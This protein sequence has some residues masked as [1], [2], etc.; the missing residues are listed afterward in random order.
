[1]NNRRLAQ[2]YLDPHLRRPEFD[3]SAVRKPL[4]LATLLRA[5]RIGELS[6]GR[7]ADKVERLYQTITDDEAETRAWT[8]NK[9]NDGMLVNI[10][11]GGVGTWLD[12]KTKTLDISEELCDFEING[13]VYRLGI[14]S[15]S[16]RDV[17]AYQVL[18]TGEM[19]P[20]MY[21]D[22]LLPQAED[23]HSL[24]VS[25]MKPPT[26]SVYPDIDLTFVRAIRACK[27]TPLITGAIGR[28]V[29]I[30]QEQGRF[31]AVGLEMQ[32]YDRWDSLD[33]TRY[34][35]SVIHARA[36]SYL[37]K[38]WLIVETIYSSAC[39]G[40]QLHAATS[41]GE[42][43]YGPLPM[44]RLWETT[45]AGDEALGRILRKMRR[46][47]I[48]NLVFADKKDVVAAARECFREMATELGI[49]RLVEA[50]RVGTV[51]ARIGKELT[52]ITPLHLRVNAD[53]A[54]MKEAELIEPRVS[55]PRP[56]TAPPAFSGPVLA[57]AT[58]E[59]AEARTEERAKLVNAYKGLFC[60]SAK[61]LLETLYEVADAK[62]AR[63]LLQVAAKENG[64][65][66][67]AL[68]EKLY[69]YE[70]ALAK[71]GFNIKLALADLKSNKSREI[72]PAM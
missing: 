7:C 38:L 15:N 37:F 49:E 39:N 42:V 36:Q 48:Q 72:Q 52:R 53:Q 69:K 62:D 18:S 35:D 29:Q 46:P 33:R 27:S 28:T 41:L 63:Y 30:Q 47:N 13:V 40:D 54:R 43:A 60:G 2:P 50:R 23:A 32:D 8:D 11:L 17:A 31:A 71:Q 44:T 34:V 5:T 67:T 70:R 59:A 65:A 12:R 16:M 64:T 51:L 1:M 14:N 6:S 10:G 26:G 4:S 9:P 61:D 21:V 22:Q 25:N 57:R 55:T 3:T 68:I 56:I 20:V 19:K 58:Q 66:E 45:Q 24:Y